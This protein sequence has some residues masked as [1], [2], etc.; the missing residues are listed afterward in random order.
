MAADAPARWRLGRETKTS[1]RAEFDG[2]GVTTTRRRSGPDD[3]ERG[4]AFIGFDECTVSHEIEREGLG[5]VG[6]GG[7]CNG[8]FE[9]FDGWR[10]RAGCGKRCFATAAAER[11]K[12]SGNDERS[13]ASLREN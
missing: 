13:G 1:H 12:Y 10:N 5:G 4:R 11:K 8:R 7:G 2:Q 3:E 6:K 9:V